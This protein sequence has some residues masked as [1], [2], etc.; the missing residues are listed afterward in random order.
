MLDLA[1]RIIC[2]ESEHR[3]HIINHYDMKYDRNIEVLNLGDTDTFMTE[4][5]IQALENKFKL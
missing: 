5:L 3:T 1:D 4:Q 2:M